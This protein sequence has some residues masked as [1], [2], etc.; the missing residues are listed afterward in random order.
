MDGLA[1]WPTHLIRMTLG[2]VRQFGTVEELSLQVRLARE[3]VDRERRDRGEGDD[4]E[5]W[6]N[7]ALLDLALGWLE[8]DFRERGPR[9]PRVAGP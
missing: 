9:G 4:G 8:E 2:Q 1:G 5:V 6:K 7:S 3:K